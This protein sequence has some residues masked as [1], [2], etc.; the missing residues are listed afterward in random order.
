VG[1]GGAAVVAGVVA[2]AVREADAVAL[3]AA[4]P[5]GLCP[6]ERR[7]ELESQ[8]ARAELLGPLGAVLLGAGVLA[9]GTGAYFLLRSPDGK[10]SVGV[11][12]VAG[13]HG[14][15]IHWRGVF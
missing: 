6:E 7:D 4:C 14:A 8:R 11:T 1:A 9:A 12:P 3:Q 10:A 13:P 2:L 15:G 5:G